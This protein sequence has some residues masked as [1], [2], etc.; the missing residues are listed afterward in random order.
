M[1]GVR[2]PLWEP[3]FSIYNQPPIKKELKIINQPHIILSISLLAGMA[4]VAQA[5]GLYVGLEGGVS[6]NNKD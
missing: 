1:S 6:I 2:I 5:E 4:S 3:T